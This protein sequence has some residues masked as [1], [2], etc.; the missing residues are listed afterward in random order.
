M[1]HFN[2]SCKW[3]FLGIVSVCFAYVGCSASEPVTF[4][5]TDSL[6]NVPA[7]PWMWI[8]E[9]PAAHR[10][11][12]QG[13]E[14]QLEPGSLMGGGTGVKNILVRPLPAGATMVDLTVDFQPKLQFEQAGLI[15][16]VN[17]D[18]YIKLVKEFV[19]GTP[20]IVM[21]IEI[22]TQIK[23]LNK[24]P[25]LEGPVKLRLDIEKDL[26]SGGY[27]DGEGKIVEAA[28]GEFPMKSQA[29]IGLFCQ[30]GTE[31]DPRWARYTDF[32]IFSAKRSSVK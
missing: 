15:L 24:I 4:P 1:I 10:S 12:E 8:R 22:D 25:A 29:Q 6:Q 32:G 23:V 30:N 9:T 17:D 7:S 18:Q 28:Y 11:S 5:I 16:Y 3:C 21:A 19:D 14:I 13:L 2:R 26:V 31:G 20:W 27:M